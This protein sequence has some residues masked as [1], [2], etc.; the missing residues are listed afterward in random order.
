M[1]Y[2]GNKGQQLL[3]RMRRKAAM[4]VAASVMLEG[5]AL[6]QMLDRYNERVPDKERIGIGAFK[7]LIGEVEKEW[8]KE[9]V[10]NVTEAMN[11]Q[12]AELE[13]IMGESKRAWRRS[14]A[15]KRTKTDTSKAKGRPVLNPLD[16]QALMTHDGRPIREGSEETCSLKVEQQNGNPA[17]LRLMLDA[18]DR[19]NDLYGFAGNVGDE[20]EDLIQ[21]ELK[22]VGELNQ[23]LAILEGGSTVPLTAVSKAESDKPYID[24][25]IQEPGTNGN[26]G[27]NG[28]GHNGNGKS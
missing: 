14:L 7:T 19:K 20:V 12:M 18:W 8:K 11:R 24:I 4:T 26:N 6:D 16:G 5:G 17:Y 3:K 2:L 21:A 27:N 22:K 13:T 25:G 10:F 23:Q 1:T 9:R 15:D 28:N